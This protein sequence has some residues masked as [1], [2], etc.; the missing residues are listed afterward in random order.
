[1][2][3]G[4]DAITPPPRPLPSLQFW[5]GPLFGGPAVALVYESIFKAKDEADDGSG[6]QAPAVGPDG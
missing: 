5:L 1:M 2:P 4:A 6:G 3:G